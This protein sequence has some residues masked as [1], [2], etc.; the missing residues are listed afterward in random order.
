MKIRTKTLF[1]IFL[2]IVVT[3]AVAVLAARTV[4]VNTVKKQIGNHLKDTAQL[5]TRYIETFFEENQKK[6]KMIASGFIFRE[7][8]AAK[9]EDVDYAL[10]YKTVQK[11]LHSLSKAIDK[12]Y[13]LSIIDKNGIIVVSTDNK[14]SGYDLSADAAFKKGIKNAFVKDIYICIGCKK[15]VMGILS[16]II[17]N[18]KSIGVVLANI[19]AKELNK[20]TTDRT[21]LGKTGE[22][23]IVNKNG[24]MI[25]PSRFAKNAVLKQK[26]DTENT[27]G[28]FKHTERFGEKEQEHKE[29]IFKNYVDK[30]VLGIH[31]HIRGVNWCLIAE[32][33]KEEAFA[34]VAAMTNTMLVVFAAFLIAGIL[35]AVP[36]AKTVTDPILR[37][38]RGVERL[39][40]GNLNYKVGT[41]AK[42]EIGELSRAFDTMAVR[43]KKSKVELEEY[44]RNFEEKVEKRTVKLKEEVRKSEEQ[45]IA[46]LNILQDLD[47][48]NENLKKQIAERKQLETNLRQAQKMEAIGTLAGGI[49]HDFNNLLFPII[50]YTEMTMRNLPEKSTDRNNLKEVL[51]ATTHATDLVKQILAFS[52]QREQERKPI[53]VQTV[54]KEVLKLIRASLPSTIE[55]LQ[56]I[57]KECCFVMADSTQIHQVIMNLCTNAYHAMMDKGGVLKVTLS[58]LEINSEDFVLNP[59]LQPGQYLKLSVSD[60]GQGIEQNIVERIFDPYFTTKEQ[61]KGTGLGLSVVHG[62]VKSYNGDIRLDSNPGKGT[63]FTVYL[64]VIDTGAVKPKTISSQPLQGGSERI[65][66]VDDNEQI[67]IM[68]KQMLERLGYNVTSRTSSVE[69]FEVFS[70]KPDNFDLVITD[71]TMPNIT[72]DQLAK[73][74]MEIRSDIPII[75]CTGFSELITK[76]KAKVM[77]IREFV[78]KPVVMNK[79]A[80]VIRRVLEQ[81][82]ENK[83]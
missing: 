34:P 8:L 6:V 56:E 74:L 15:P 44:S 28:Y 23:Y 73:K 82:K 58:E 3:G 68:E 42:D 62:I 19:K 77:G 71:M 69:A 70:N 40:N 24:Y 54:L 80:E 83:P 53:K 25:T 17:K 63:T 20:I 48:V 72:G 55:L 36:I 2:L 61:G 18:N 26:V 11:R 75:L 5:R 51:N 81:K 21:G 1:M 31:S 59:D 47:E 12:F 16:P 49:A 64:P 57:D 14:L 13:N 7:L 27:R 10:K 78:M 9:K 35:F 33:N 67:V 29:F 76:E 45:K 52:R 60:T 37:L 43:L 46:T 30:D 50:G 22:I 39:R 79:I 66:L 41:K 32:I 65:L 38:R 4:A